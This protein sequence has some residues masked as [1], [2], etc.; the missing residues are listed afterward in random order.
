MVV[1]AFPITLGKSELASMNWA[2]I[3]LLALSI[4]NMQSSY[5]TT[6]KSTGDGVDIVK[7]SQNL[8][9]G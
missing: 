2:I 1:I 3:F 8:S 5:N 4:I 9:V 6:I 7:G